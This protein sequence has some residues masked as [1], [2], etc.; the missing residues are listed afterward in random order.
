MSKT[1]PKIPNPWNEYDRLSF[2]W[3]NYNQ[4]IWNECKG[5]LSEYTWLHEVC[6]LKRRVEKSEVGSVRGHWS[7]EKHLKVLRAVCEGRS[8]GEQAFSSLQPR[9]GWVSATAHELEGG[10]SGLQKV[11]PPYFFYLVRFKGVYTRRLM[12]KVWYGEC[13]NF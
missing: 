7:H 13:L 10:A 3:S 1:A 9:K 4:S 8:N 12:Y 5:R 11:Q 6:L 2:M